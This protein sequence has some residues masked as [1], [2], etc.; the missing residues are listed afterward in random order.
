MTIEFE[1]KSNDLNRTKIFTINA[2]E[3]G[4]IIG[5]FSINDQEN[6]RINIIHQSLQS[7]SKKIKEI[8]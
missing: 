6:L 2:L 5:N 4:D 8:N 3:Y 1:E 7:V